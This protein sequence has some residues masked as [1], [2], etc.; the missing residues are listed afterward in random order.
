MT[1]TAAATL[2]TPFAL[3]TS[4]LLHHVLDPTSKR[5]AKLKAKLPGEC[6]TAGK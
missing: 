1:C 3:Q 4:D 2:F 6:Q 5:G